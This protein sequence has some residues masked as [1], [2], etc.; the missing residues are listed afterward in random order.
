VGALRRFLHR[1]NQTDE[2]LL[3]EEVRTW[4][5]SIPGTVRI[6]DARYRTKVKL[7]G[8]VRRITVRPVEGFQSVE[9]VLWDGTGDVHAVWLGRRQVT[10]M[11]LGSRLILEG[12]LGKE[13]GVSRIV[14]PVFE[15]A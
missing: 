9:A 6:G 3:A 5:A 7:A 11:T 8:I 15:F 10:G 13:R 4:A 14:N 1:L 2:D 12:I